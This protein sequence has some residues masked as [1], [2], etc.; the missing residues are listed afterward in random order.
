MSYLMG[1][2]ERTI[3]ELCIPCRQLAGQRSAK[4]ARLLLLLQKCPTPEQRLPVEITL[5]TRTS[6]LLSRCVLYMALT[7]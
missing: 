7:R 4:Q 6:L 3:K 5:T 2:R 1:C